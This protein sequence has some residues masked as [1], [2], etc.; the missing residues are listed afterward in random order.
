[1]T[2]GAGVSYTDAYAVI[3]RRFP[4]LRELW[5]RIGGEQVRNMGTI[6]GNIANGSPI[7]DTPPALIALG[8]VL[9]LRGPDGPREMA[10][11]EFFVDYGKQDRQAD[12]FVESVFVPALPE[13]ADLAA[14]K[15]TKRLD[16]DITATLGAFR[17]TR[18]GDAVTDVRLAFGGM[19]ATP[20]RAA[21][22]EAAI[23]GR[24][25]SAETARA[26]MAA[27]EDDFA[28][29]SDWRASA[30]YRRLAA[31]N[32]IWRFWLETGERAVG[33]TRL[34]RPLAEAI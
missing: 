21:G 1:M 28:P 29:L 20:K 2:F 15:I 7:G 16:E 18:D 25:W 12:E 19:A 31:K 11:E 23:L 33:A 9:R 34:D 13:G 5:D 17:L 14:Y 6:G 26:A 3:S 22:A 8:A 24:P 30:E 32:L 27:L 4:A 10:L